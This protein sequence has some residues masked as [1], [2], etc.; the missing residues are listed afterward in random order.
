[1][2][3]NKPNSPEGLSL[4]EKKEIQKLTED[5]FQ[6]LGIPIEIEKF[7]FKEQVLLINLNTTEPRV[8][9]GHNGQTL[10]EIQH[11]LG[12]IIR[13]KNKKDFFLNLDIENYKKKKIEYLKEL[14]QSL[15]D[16]VVI[17]KEE[18]ILPPLSAFE[19]RIIHLELAQR[20]DIT[21]QSTG[22]GSERRIVIKPVTDNL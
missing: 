3:K 19:R 21:T 8:L 15:A 7:S 14:A 4:K 10:S 17:Y 11:L 12:K 16:E 22:Q 18:K 6:K 9:I 1:M 2:I 13:K 5:F 20:E